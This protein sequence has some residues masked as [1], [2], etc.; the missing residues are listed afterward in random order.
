MPLLRLPVP[1]EPGFWRRSTS[2]LSSVNSDFVASAPPCKLRFRLPAK[3]T[4]Y[5]GEYF[6]DFLVEDE[7]VIELRCVEHLGDEHTARNSSTICAHPT[8]ALFAHQFHKPKAQ[9]KRI[10]QDFNSRPTT[11]SFIRVNQ[12]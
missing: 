7:L 1:W 3:A 11:V 5:V 2:V 9:W 6:A 4:I 10:V 8:D 12:R